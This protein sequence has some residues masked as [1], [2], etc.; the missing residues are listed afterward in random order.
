MP[1]DLI[2]YL[3]HAAAAIAYAVLALWQFRRSD[4][5]IQQ[6]VYG[7]ALAMTSLWAVA[8][9]VAGPLTVITGVMTSARNLMWLTYLFVLFSRG[10][11]VAGRRTITVLYVMLFAGTLAKIVLGFTPMFGLSG[12][13]DLGRG[14]FFVSL[15]LR[16]L[17]L[18]GGMMLIHNLYLA[19]LPAERWRVRGPLVAIA[20]MWAW[21]LNL[22][23]VAYLNG[24][25]PGTLIAYRGVMVMALAIPFSLTGVRRQTGGLRFSRAAAFQSASLLAIG[26]YLIFMVL[27]TRAMALIGGQNFRLAQV[28]IV[29]IMSV[30][31]AVLLPSPRVRAWLRVTIAKHFFAHRYDYREEW[32]RFTGTLGRP[33][34]ESLPLEARA[35]KA[36]ADITESPGGL[37]LVD[38]GGGGLTCGARWHWPIIDA[39]QVADAGDLVR[40]LETTGRVLEL[41]AL[42]EGDPRDDAERALVP[43]WLLAESS[44]WIVVPLIHIDRLTG[45][46][47]VERPR[48]DR[49]LDWE[50]FDLLK[51]AGRQVASYLAEAH[52]QEALSEANRFDEFNRRFAFILHDIKNIVS[53]LS[54]VARNA[55]RHAD[56]PDFRAD[57]VATL[58]SSVGKMNALLALLATKNRTE[59]AAQR[60]LPLMPFVRALAAERRQSNP[61][62]VDGW[63]NVVAVTDPAR[64][65]QALVH[66]VQNAVDASDPDAP[67]H[68]AV[69]ARGG[70]ATISVQ[71]SG[72]GMSAEFI[73][74]DLFK[75]FSSTKANGFGV[76]A[77]EA[78]S[79]LAAMGGSLEVE[80]RPG[81]GSRFTILL[82]L[83]G[84]ETG[85]VPPP[86]AAT[87]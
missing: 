4:R 43:D 74:N 25:W 86:H 30:A 57:M 77:F 27:A 66:I 34:D 2:G 18:A 39:P 3:G 73:R 69:G 5:T 42:R 85:A 22:Y 80:S 6:R 17:V 64:L 51:I 53:Q 72:R 13:G 47:A 1:I 11:G 23:T 61:L 37:L 44:A 62:V 70:R 75:P 52:S 78:R 56:N 48:S 29:I 15:V 46:V 10:A 16:I 58:Q 55:E 33:G 63:D 32:L 65:E 20:G 35:I 19:T 60:P 87:A 21:D 67:I 38:D 14:I 7:A 50:D 12:G 24:G 81:E 26:G 59:P 45:M 76:G 8:T 71:D 54:L 28:A 36:I 9:I 68:I 49:A 41:D 82:P 84:R 40:H 31:A 79:L 83:T